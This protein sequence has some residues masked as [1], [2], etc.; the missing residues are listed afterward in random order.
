M[1]F[2]QGE[3][4]TV[5]TSVRDSDNVLTNPTTSITISITDADGV[6][7]VTDQAMTNDSTGKYHYDHALPA[8]AVAGVWVAE[9]TASSGKPSIE[10]L[11]F[12]VEESL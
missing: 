2:Y 6:A 12:L 8:D 10:Q 1:G 3:T 7:R 9:V 5:E 4:V 11:S